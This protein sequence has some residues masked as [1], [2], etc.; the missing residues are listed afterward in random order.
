MLFKRPQIAQI[1]QMRIT[2]VS[3]GILLI[4][5]ICVR[6]YYCPINL[7]NLPSIKKLNL[8]KPMN[9]TKTIKTP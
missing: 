7:C 6:N 4:C 8:G 5:A 2:S 3:E 9:N 1:S